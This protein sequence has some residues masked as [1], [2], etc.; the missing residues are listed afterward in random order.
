MAGYKGYS[1]SNNAVEAYL[2]GEKPMSKWTKTDIIGAIK[3]LVENEELI[4]KFSIEKLKKIPLNTLKDLCLNRSSWHHTSKHYNKTDF[5]SI[6]FVVLE[7]LTDEVIAELSETKNE[8]EESKAETRKVKY[9]TWS[10]TKKHPKATEHIEEVEVV[11]NWAYTSNGK[12]SIK[13][14][15]FEFL[16]V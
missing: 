14:N 16:E 11:G 6:D 7:K 8:K 13:A 9:L 3:E 12:K 2:D 1:M 10:G 4:V 5:Y 15:G